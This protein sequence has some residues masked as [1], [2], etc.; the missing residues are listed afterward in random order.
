[1]LSAVQ[2]KFLLTIYYLNKEDIPAKNMNVA[3]I[4]GM[5]QSAVSRISAVFQNNGIIEKK[6]SQGA[7]FT[8]R[9]MT[10]IKN[11]IYRYNKASDFLTSALKLDKTTAH[12]AAAGI[13]AE[14]SDESIEAMYGFVCSFK[15]LGRCPNT[16]QAFE[17]A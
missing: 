3:E 12:K 6:P 9:G 10:E 8:E 15:T 16:P 5:S 17:K 14:I 13:A 11:L 4:L 1:M 7:V 2:I